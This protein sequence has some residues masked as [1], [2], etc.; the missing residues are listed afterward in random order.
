MTY[1]AFDV[2]GTTIK[3]GLVHD[4]LSIS[5][6]GKK[7]TNNNLN[8]QILNTILITAEYF[9]QMEPTIAGIGISTAGTVGHDGSIQYAGPT[10]PNYQGTKLQEIVTQQTGLPT[11]VINDVDAALLGE[12]QAGA[13]QNN[14]RVYCVA[15]GT[16]IG[17]AFLVNGQLIQGKH[18]TANSL[19]TTLF[20]SRSQTN[21]EQRAA[22]LV[23]ERDLK[24]LATSVQ[25]AFELAKQ[26]QQPF[27]KMIRN[28]VSEV[29][30]GLAQVIL[31][32][33]PDLII[34]GGAVSLQ[35]DYLLNMLTAE[36]KKQLPPELNQ[37]QIKM[38]QLANDAQLIGAITPFL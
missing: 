6:H 1:L 12:W 23:L 3:Y 22:T 16:G 28:W 8:N 2:G 4:D 34:I 37:T 17:G 26:G 27:N 18:G 32:H 5:Q 10:I 38:A 19:G 31:L 33:D 20:D 14:Q 9:Q 21:Y 30:C 36:L 7:T 35:G 25:K 29:A 24:P 15:I 13:A 11:H